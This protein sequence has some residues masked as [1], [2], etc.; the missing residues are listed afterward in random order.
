MNTPRVDAPTGVLR[1]KPTTPAPAGSGRQRPDRAPPADTLRRE[2]TY[3][4]L[5]DM[6]TATYLFARGLWV[7]AATKLTRYRFRFTFYDPDHL[8]EQAVIDF[9]NACC[10]VAPIDFADAQRR[11][12]SVIHKFDGRSDDSRKGRGSNG[13]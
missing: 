1:G 8:A 12:K 7:Q 10:D 2:G 9:V 6:D 4:T 5:S 13:R 3:V 11:L